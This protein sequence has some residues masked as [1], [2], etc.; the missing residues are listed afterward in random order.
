VTEAEAAGIRG[1]QAAR[2]GRHQDAV[3]AYREACAVEPGNAVLRYDLALELE[4][5]GDLDGA[6]RAFH[7]AAALDVRDADALSDLGRLEIA[8]DRRAAA[9]EALDAALRRDPVHPRGWN[10]RGVL[11][12]LDGEYEAAERAF[13]TAVALDSS[14]AD[15]WFN[16]ADTRDELGDREGGAEA[17]RRW[18]DSG[19][20]V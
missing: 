3:A 1:R 9:R 16:L 17:R 5:V 11:H 15:A 7:D 13:S 20:D 18:R 8:A 2:E 12:F 4:A 19:G 6:R 14:L 10:N